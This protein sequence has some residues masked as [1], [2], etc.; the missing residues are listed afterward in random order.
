LN[1]EDF[2]AFQKE[3]YPHW[4]DGF[5]L[6]EKVWGEGFRGF[7]D[8][9][10]ERTDYNPEGYVY[11]EKIIE[12]CRAK[13]I[14]VVL[15]KSPCLEWSEA[16]YNAAQAFASEMHVDYY[17]FH[18]QDTIDESGLNFEIDVAD[19]LHANTSGAIKVTRYLGKMLQAHGA[20]P[21]RRDDPAYAYLRAD[22]ERYEREKGQSL[23]EIAEAQGGE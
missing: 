5:V 20:L 19:V 10:A 15:Y 13:G 11:L 16:S 6:N 17:D 18:R 14:E 2:S 9:G 8:T 4:H 23:K 3:E 22:Y 1:K 12:L 7:V 21:D